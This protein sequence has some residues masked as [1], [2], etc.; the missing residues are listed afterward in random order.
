MPFHPLGNFPRHR[1]VAT[2]PDDI[3]DRLVDHVELPDTDHH[4]HRHHRTDRG[5][6]T[7][8]K[9]FDFHF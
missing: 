4:Q 8:E 6:S 5:K 1:F 9:R 7:P 3:V 2:R